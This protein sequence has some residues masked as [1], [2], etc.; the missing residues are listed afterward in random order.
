ML[1]SQE[2]ELQDIN[3][4]IYSSDPNDYEYTN[5][6]KDE[7]LPEDARNLTWDLVEET[8]ETGELG[9]VPGNADAEFIQSYDGVE[10]YV[11]VGY[12]DHQ[13]CPVAITSWTSV[14]E[15]EVAVESDRWTRDQLEQILD[16]NGAEPLDTY[17]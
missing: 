4:L 12:D 14:Q 9:Q 8:I 5:H 1:K 6:L 13:D 10:V 11:L 15:A 7:V 3:R 17:L 16:F 2:V